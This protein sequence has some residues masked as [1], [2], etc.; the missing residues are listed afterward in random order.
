VVCDIPVILFAGR[1][2][3][4]ILVTWLGMVQGSMESNR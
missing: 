3:G 2:L 4:S 1:V